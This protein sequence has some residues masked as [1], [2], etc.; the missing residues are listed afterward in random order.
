MGERELRDFLTR[1]LAAGET[2]DACAYGVERKSRAERLGGLLGASLGGWI[3]G[4][5]VIDDGW[6][7]ATT[8]SR[9]LSVRVRRVARVLGPPKL[10][11]G[12]VHAHADAH[13]LNAVVRHH[14][15]RMVLELVLE[16]QQRSLWFGP[17]TGFSDNVQRA[18]AIAEWLEVRSR[19]GSS[20][21]PGRY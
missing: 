13:A 19:G 16:E 3:G 18:R 1:Q 11:F 21:E 6:G 12:T 4:A 20:A 9:L 14:E 10:R 15:G 5:L 17:V 2:L 8:S 7:L